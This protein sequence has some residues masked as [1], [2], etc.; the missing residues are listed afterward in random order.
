[1]RQKMATLFLFCLLAGVSAW[2]PWITQDR[3]SR[4][5]E[6]QFNQV[7]LT[8]IDGCGTSGKNLGTKD[9]RKVPFGGFVTVD[10]QCGLVM[11]G[12]PVLHSTVYVSFFGIASGYPKP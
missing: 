8:V 5:A 12:E 1:M 7:W 2:S 6:T 3:A 10:Y 9:F 4:L 11:P